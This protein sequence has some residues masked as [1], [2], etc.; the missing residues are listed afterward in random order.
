[1]GI[2][3]ILDGGHACENLW[4]FG[5]G[6]G[7]DQYL[8]RLPRHSAHVSDVQK[9]G[10]LNDELRAAHFCKAKPHSNSIPGR[11]RLKYVSERCRPS[12]SL[13]RCLV[14]LST[15]RSFQSCLI[16]PR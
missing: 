6:Y 11:E 3:T 15:A 2:E 14:Y 12:L 9:E 7:V 8:R 5:F 1:M 13:S 10:A 4:L 16:A